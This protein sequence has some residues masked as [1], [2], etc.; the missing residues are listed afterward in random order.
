MTN[1][2]KT[3]TP[4]LTAGL[5]AIILNR[6]RTAQVPLPVGEPDKEGG[7][8]LRWLGG[9]AHEIHVLADGRIRAQLAFSVGEERCE[10]ALHQILMTL[11]QS[12]KGHYA[13]P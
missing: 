9:T 3:L 13:R 10:G 12:I 4:I 8:Y 5:V 7:F 11:E 1:I 6:C 2:Q